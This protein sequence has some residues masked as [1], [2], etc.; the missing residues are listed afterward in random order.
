MS[1]IG[2]KPIEILDGVII[3]I[4]G[5]D[6][7]VKGPK[8]ELSHTLHPLVKIEQTDKQLIL[9]SDRPPGAISA[10][11]E[12]LSSRLSAG[13]VADIKKPDY[14]TRLA[15]L[16]QKSAKKGLAIDK[17]ALEAA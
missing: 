16:G 3:K 15:I 7:S 4:D 5:Q 14:E 9:S 10:F 8:G 13:M 2:K 17:S 11:Q 12:R 6:I 1:R